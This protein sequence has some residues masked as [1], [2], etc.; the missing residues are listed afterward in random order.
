MAMR[1]KTVVTVRDVCHS[2]TARDVCHSAT[3]RDVCH[4]STLPKEKNQND[5][6]EIEPG[7]KPATNSLC[8]D[9]ASNCY[10]SDAQW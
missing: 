3:D 9:K 6:L 7:T 2:A 1:G 10:H 4:S 8:H 5:G